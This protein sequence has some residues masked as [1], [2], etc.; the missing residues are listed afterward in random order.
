MVVDGDM[1]PHHTARSRERGEDKRDKLFL[2][3]A[4]ARAIL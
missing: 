3:S 4:R 1:S 2:L